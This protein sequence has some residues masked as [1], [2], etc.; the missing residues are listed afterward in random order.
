MRSMLNI[1]KHFWLLITVKKYIKKY[2]LKVK[3]RNHFNYIRITTTTN[4]LYFITLTQRCNYGKKVKK[5][6]RNNVSAQIILLTPNVDYRKIFNEHLELLGVI[7][8]KKSLAGF[9]NDIS[10]YLDY[11]F[12]IE[13]VH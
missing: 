11:F 4:S 3:V 13:K 5:I 12:N 7:D 1:V 10:G 6:R 8:I 9:T 2:K